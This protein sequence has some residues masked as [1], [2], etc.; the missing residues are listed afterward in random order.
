MNSEDFITILG[1]LS[2]SL[3]PVQNLI[4]GGSYLLG[5][6]FF[7]T[8]LGKLRSVGD[9]QAQP[10][11][12]ASLMY[13]FFGAGLFYLPTFMTTLANTVFGVG[14]I[15]NYAPYNQGGV[16]ESM[17]I[18]IRTAGLLWFVRGCVLLA[19]SSEP[20]A[21]DGSKGL[22]FLFAGVL[23]MNLDITISMVNNAIMHLID[24]SES[25]KSSQGY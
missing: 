9:R 11:T 14:N 16:Y 23:A 8:A 10:S 2:Q 4:T 21:K 1:N 17:S 13:F 12:F 25:I 6:I 18:I 7:M 19:H 5:M 20:G 3:I 22:V 15:L 24:W